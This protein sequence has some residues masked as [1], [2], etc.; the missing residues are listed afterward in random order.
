MI[1]STNLRSVSHPVNLDLLLPPLRDNRGSR[2]QGE[3]ATPN[4]VKISENVSES[5]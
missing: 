1:I 2:F 3:P 5:V 4:Y